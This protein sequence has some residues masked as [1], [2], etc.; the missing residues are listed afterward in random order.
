MSRKLFG[1]KIKNP[2]D[3]FNDAKAKADKLRM[4][5]ERKLREATAKAISDA[6]EREQRLRDKV[7]EQLSKIKVPMKDLP[8]VQLLPFK[9]I[10]I[11]A[12]DRR[13]V[14][15]NTELNDIAPKFL[16]EVVYNQSRKPVQTNMLSGAMLVRPMQQNSSKANFENFYA[17]EVTYTEEGS[18]A[19]QYEAGAKETKGMI[20]KIIA[21]FKERKAKKEAEK[22]ARE[23]GTTD[24][25][26]G[27]PLTPEENAMLNEADATAQAI[28]GN[29]QNEV[30]AE[31]DGVM[32]TGFSV[33]EI[34]IGVVI[35][36]LLFFG[37]KK[38]FKG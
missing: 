7:Q 13:H 1:G 36:T 33:V 18:T 23:T 22:L 26:G 5:A 9:K 2:K 19:S 4:D 27:E 38:L 12:L 17:E 37:L 11:D 15:H 8:F 10:M 16:K 31:N 6:K 34:L 24:N 21:W 32:G 28:V 20:Q 35:A 29:A 3:T 14:S 30:D 25:S